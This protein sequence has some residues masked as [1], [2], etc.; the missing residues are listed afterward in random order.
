[1]IGK[2]NAIY[3]GYGELEIVTSAIPRL[4]FGYPFSVQLI[5]KGGSRKGYTFELLDWLP[6]GITFSESGMLSG[7]PMQSG[8]YSAR[9][10]RVTDSDG[11]AATRGLRISIESP[12]VIFRATNNVYTYDGKP[13]KATLVPV[14]ANPGYDFSKLTEDVDYYVYY[15][16]DRKKRDVT[17][18]ITC[19]IDIGY[20][21]NGF[22][23]K[24]QGYMQV[25]GSDNYTLSLPQKTVP[26]DGQPHEIVPVIVNNTVP[27]EEITYKTK[28]KG[29]NGTVYAETETPPTNAGTYTVTVTTTGSNYK[30]KTASSILTITA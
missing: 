3:P 26:Y 21:K 30:R 7:T 9:V 20:L 27:G 5:A 14:S 19:I 17:E 8:A 12:E 22:T 29:R 2:T 11:N 4:K 18:A 15:L 6:A 28:Y 23:A 1:M 24:V 25:K 16:G 10:F 13:H